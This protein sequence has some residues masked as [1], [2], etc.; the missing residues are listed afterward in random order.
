MFP[1]AAQL[2]A[3]YDRNETK[4]RDRTG[5]ALPRDTPFQNSGCPTIRTTLC[6][7]DGVSRMSDTETTGHRDGLARDVIRL[8]RGEEGDESGFHGSLPG[9]VA[10]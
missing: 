7:P 3:R 1:Y 4:K 10:R 9:T 5:L 8:V 2:N 6:R